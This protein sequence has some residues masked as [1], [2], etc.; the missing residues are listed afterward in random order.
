MHWNGN[1]WAR[2]PKVD[3]ACQPHASIPHNDVRVSRL[4]YKNSAGMLGLSRP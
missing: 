1:S 2:L 3:A 4:S